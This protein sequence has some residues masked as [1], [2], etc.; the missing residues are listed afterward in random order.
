MLVLFV[1]I[2]IVDSDDCQKYVSIAVTPT[3]A[4]VVLDLGLFTQTC[5]H[6]ILRD[7]KLSTYS[8]LKTLIDISFPFFHQSDYYHRNFCGGPSL[9]GY[10]HR[11][12]KM[13]FLLYLRHRMPHLVQTRALETK[14]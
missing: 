12:K 10:C 11:E 13:S 4:T 2:S 6:H 14:W 9:N 3:H 5:T 8:C 7:H 1:L